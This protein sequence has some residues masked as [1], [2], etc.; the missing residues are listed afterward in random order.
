VYAEGG[1]SVL[2]ED[3]LVARDTG[4]DGGAATAEEAAIHIIDG[5]AIPYSEE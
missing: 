5:S 1:T 4:I 3:E 2:V